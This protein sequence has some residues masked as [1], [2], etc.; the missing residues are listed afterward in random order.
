MG[1]AALQCLNCNDLDTMRNISF[2]NQTIRVIANSCL[3]Q[4][5]F[6]KK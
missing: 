1:G 6:L 5:L 2:I 4:G 3:A